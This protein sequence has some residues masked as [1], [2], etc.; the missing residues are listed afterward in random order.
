MTGSSKPSAA[1]RSISGD[2]SAKAW[3]GKNKRA[4]RNKTGRTPALRM[5][6]MK[7]LSLPKVNFMSTILKEFLY[8]KTQNFRP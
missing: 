5:P 1:R 2:Q 3:Q 6:G 4:V 7:A 8:S